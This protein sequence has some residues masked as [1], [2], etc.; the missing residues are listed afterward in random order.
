MSRVEEES[1][2][3]IPSWMECET[4]ET[5]EAYA[6]VCE[7]MCIHELM[8][9]LKISKHINYSEEC[10]NKLFD[11]KD[12]LYMRQKASLEKEQILTN[13]CEDEVIALSL[14]QQE[15]R[16]MEQ[17]AEDE[18]IA[19]SLQDQEEKIYHQIFMDKNLAKKLSN[20]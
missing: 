7:K 17:M 18:A 9:N 5:D 15:E 13:I 1:K 3:E 2:G 11:S 10:K 19:R 8:R 4:K 16:T 12:T 6:K 14:R 20:S